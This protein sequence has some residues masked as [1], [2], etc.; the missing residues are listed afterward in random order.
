MDEIRQLEGYGEK[1]VE[2]LQAGIEESK[3]RLVHRLLTALGIRYVGSVVAE[4]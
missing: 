1:R 4:P 3:L 2:N